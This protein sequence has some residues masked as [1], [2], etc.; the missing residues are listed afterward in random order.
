ME[1]KKIL[2]EIG[3]GT[4]TVLEVAQ[5]LENGGKKLTIDL[6]K[7]L[8][9]EA[10]EP[11][12]AESR[13][14]HH[15]FHSAASLADYLARYGDKST[16][17]FVDHEEGR[18]SAVLSETSGKGFEIVTMEPQVHPL[19]EPWRDIAGEQQDIKEFAAFVMQNRRSIA[20]PDG[21]NLA[22]DLQQIRGSVSVEIMAGRGRGAVNGL[23]VRSR[24]N[25]G[26]E[27]TDTVDLP[28]SI[29]LKVPLYVDTEAREL[30]LDLCIEAQAS[31]S[32]TVLV[33]EGTVAEARVAAFNDMVNR[34]RQGVKA[35]DA[36]VTW[37]SPKHQEWLY[38]KEL[39]AG[40]KA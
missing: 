15:A 7:L 13:A 25:A 30:E 36:L 9:E 14:R 10:R 28:D 11:K 20:K 16:V 17:V 19:W 1:V 18:I 31:G 38:L 12:R 40:E 3:V 22:L 24:V 26:N 27:Q 4:R 8:P 34:I 23:V 39:N 6:R 32:V 37:G 2:E 5:D 33:S 35:I 29:T 21:R